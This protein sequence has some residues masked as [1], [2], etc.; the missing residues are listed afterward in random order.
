MYAISLSSCA[1]VYTS[2]MIFNFPSI[3]F[4][5]KTSK[6]QVKYY[7][8]HVCTFKAIIYT[9]RKIALQVSPD[10]YPRTAVI[11]EREL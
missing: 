7:P 5:C 10:E 8:E 1:K 3:F 4:F 2:Q 9:Y 6:I 11:N